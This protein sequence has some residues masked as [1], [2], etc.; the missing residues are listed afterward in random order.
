VSNPEGHPLGFQIASGN[1]AGVFTINSAG[2]LTVASAG[3]LDYETLAR[4]TQRPVQF[5]LFIDLVD[6]TD[7]SLSETGRRVVVAITNVNEPPALAGAALSILERTSRGT[8]IMILAASDPDFYTLLSF[9]ISSGNE[10][11]LF[12]VDPLSGLLRIARDV[13]SADLGTHDLSIA[14]SDQASPNPLVVT[15]SV[16][17]TVLPNTS[18]LQPG[19]ITYTAYTN[20][21][22]SGMSTLLTSPRFPSEPSFEKQLTSFEADSNWAD[23][24]GAALRGYLIPPASGNYT[25][26]VASDDGSQLWFSTST[27]PVAAA[28]IATVTDGN[29][30]SPREW[31]RFP[32]QKSQTIALN[33]GEAYYVEARL[34]EMTGNDHLAVA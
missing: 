30:T 31:D 18:P 2:L 19:A 34:R 24:Y 4:D 23:R 5:E 21:A 9:S 3:L 1:E 29:W 27:N 32:S 6:L 17:V 13:T 22:G 28:Q 8:P 16:A 14:V 7:G 15:S 33:A 12:S 20:L 25:F 26:W 11:D 10:A